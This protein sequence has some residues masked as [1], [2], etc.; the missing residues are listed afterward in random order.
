MKTMTK[1][2]KRTTARKTKTKVTKLPESK[3]YYKG[4]RDG[5]SDGQ[6]R[7]IRIGRR[8]G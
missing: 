6:K 2:K 4:Y 5:H 1:A 7:G 3:T 8:R